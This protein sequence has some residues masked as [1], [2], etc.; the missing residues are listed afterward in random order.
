MDFVY[1]QA[2]L[3]PDKKAVCCH[4]Q[5]QLVLLGAMSLLLDTTVMATF[6]KP[7]DSVW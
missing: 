7:F 2:K 6:W 5:P 1:L 4:Q 3:Q